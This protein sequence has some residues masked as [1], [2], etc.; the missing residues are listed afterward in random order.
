[1]VPNITNQVFFWFHWYSTIIAWW[2]LILVHL[3]IT[4]YSKH[5]QTTIGFHSYFQPQTPD[6]LGAKGRQPRRHPEGSP[7]PRMRPVFCA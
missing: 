7:R 2:Y 6:P 5:P 4:N 1:M 3:N